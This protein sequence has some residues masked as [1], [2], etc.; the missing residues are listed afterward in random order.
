MN[1]TISCE[2]IRTGQF[3]SKAGYS[4]WLFIPPL[5][6]LFDCGENLTTTLYSKVFAIEHIFLSHGHWDHVGGLPGLIHARLWSK[7]D[8]QKP[9]HIHYPS[10]NRGCLEI[11]EFIEKTIHK[12]SEIVSWIPLTA[13]DSIAIANNKQVKCYTTK[14][15]DQASLAYAVVET[16][17]KL[18]PAYSHLSPIALVEL[19][20]TTPIMIELDTT[21]LSIS[22]DTDTNSPYFLDHSHGSDFNGAVKTLFHECTLLNAK[23][24][25]HSGHT[26]IEQLMHSYRDYP[27]IFPENLVLY[28]LSCR[29]TL[30]ESKQRI[31]DIINP[32][33]K[34]YFPSQ[35]TY[36]IFLLYDDKLELV[37][38][39]KSDDQNMCYPNY[40]LTDFV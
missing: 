32:Y 19:K 14:H 39:K 1:N 10:S 34:F 24:V 9:I 28:H 21:I 37:I 36:N 29:N 11:K 17:H 16:R 8:T 18:N 3:F 26:E 6:T 7:G 38:S 5:R 4:T 23:E 2:Y 13:G 12:S 35:K 31:Q 15:Y 20:K 33:L 22:G 30:E 27:E 40:E 25:K